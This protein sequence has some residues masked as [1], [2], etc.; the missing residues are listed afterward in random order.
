MADI[1]QPV[2]GTR[3]FYPE[4]KAVI[5]WLYEKMGEVSERFGYQEFDGPFLEYI[6]LYAA[7][8]GEELVKEQSFVFEDKSGNLLALRPELT[9]TLVRMIA[10]RQQHLY[11]PLRW[12]SFG[13]FWRYE[14]PQKGRGREFFQWNVDLIG[15]DSP[16]A[17]AELAAV[18]AAFFQ[19]IGLAPAQTRILI[20]NRRLMDRE[21]AKLEIPPHERNDIFHL[22]DK[23]DKMEFPE[24]EAYAEELGLSLSQ[25]DGLQALLEN[26]QLWEESEELVRFFKAVDA[27]GASEYVEFAPYIIRGLDY[28]TGTVFEAQALTADVSR[29]IAG[30]G[31]YD[32]LLSDVGGD[33][34]PGVGFAAGDMVLIVVLEELGLLPEKRDQTP[35]P[36]IVTVFDEDTR[37]AS[38]S[39]AAELRRAGL[40]V[41]CYPEV[42]KL[43]KQFR[44]AN[45][46]GSRVA[47][48][49]GP[50]ELAEGMVAVKDLR[51]RDQVQVPRDEAAE[52]IQ[53]LL[54][55]DLSA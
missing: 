31:R 30:G 10:Q 37:M 18:M 49:L 11:Y 9:P 47:T 35:A 24:W 36:V 39:L 50:E 41:N 12:W 51:E 14:S 5:T 52:Y 3:D 33:P 26:D 55:K 13:P 17:D 45:R 25:M 7:K 28:Y 20:N 16:E 32:D 42:E 1:I 40:K 8:S 4:D 2:K 38:F 43:G 44:H 54:E 29:A 6:D 21:L 48:I 23:R 46:I 22:I 15:A 19:E 34:L 27:L 53:G